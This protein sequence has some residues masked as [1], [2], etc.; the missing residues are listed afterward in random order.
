MNNIQY[1]PI[2]VPNELNSVGLLKSVIGQAFDGLE[3]VIDTL[4]D[5]HVSDIRLSISTNPRDKN[6]LVIAPLAWVFTYGTLK[7]DELRGDTMPLQRLSATLVAEY[8]LH[9][10]RYGFPALKPHEIPDEE[11][12]A[13]QP[14][15][16]ELFQV[17]PTQ[18]RMLDKIESTDTGLYE[19][20]KE[21]VRIEGT[22]EH[23]KAWVYIGVDPKLFKDSVVLNSGKWDGE[24]ALPRPDKE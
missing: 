22:G 13:I 17:T 21:T 8:D 9:D 6:R 1:S 10:T 18:L 19:R 16:G 20:R 5:G 15:R 4:D 24:K 14:V 2:T 3:V 23:V 11:G 12:G 7:S